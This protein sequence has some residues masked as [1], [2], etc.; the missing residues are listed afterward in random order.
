M[1]TRKRT[2]PSLNADDD[3][4]ELSPSKPTPA[5]LSAVKKRKLNTYGS[6]NKETSVLT[7]LTDLFGLGR[8]EKENISA[9]GEKDEL[10][11]DD[12]EGDSE[13]E[14]EEGD[15]WEVPDEEEPGMVKSGTRARGTLITPGKGT[16][17]SRGKG[18]VGE[19]KA[20]KKDIYEVDDSEEDMTGSTNVRAKYS[21]YRI[22]HA[23]NSAS[24]VRE[25]EN[26]TPQRPRGRPPKLTDTNMPSPKRP[27][28]KPR[29]ADILKKAKALS[30][31]AI[32]HQMVENGR[33]SAQNSEEAQTSARRRSRRSNAEVEEVD[34]G[35]VE[36]EAQATT[37]PRRRE[38]PKHDAVESVREAPKG[39][40]TP[41]K[42]R[43]V[44]SRKSVAFESR[45]DIDL[46]FKDLPD[47]VNKI[48]TLKKGRKPRVLLY[49]DTGEP[50]SKGGKGK[51]QVHSA[52]G[53]PQPEA[54]E[55]DSDD[56]PCA[57]CKGLDS[58][59]GNEII[60]CDNCDFAAHQKCY[61]VLKIPKGDWFCRDCQPDENED[62]LG[63]EGDNDVSVSKVFDDFPE[64]EGCEDHLRHMQRVLLDRLTG[65]KPV[66][67]R[68]H[69]EEMRKVHQVIEQT[70]LAGEGNSMLII[71]ARGCGKTTVSL[72]FGDL[73]Q[74]LSIVQ[75]VESV[76]SDLSIDHRGN[77]HVVRLNGFIHTDD[78]LALKEIWRQLGREIDAEDEMTGKVDSTGDFSPYLC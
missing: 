29:K 19:V 3:E 43:T 6:K 55:A 8:S 2:R 48:S 35:D 62:P 17:T 49:E 18:K 59:K 63:L 20:L 1:S 27:A 45:D 32:F 24:K 54:E 16:P 23:P 22:P 72:P 7:K 67:L 75:L 28:G 41:T 47:S 33:K 12:E 73:E 58:K 14:K 53:T 50:T 38:R 36:E 9:A 68:G 74:L 44:K 66:K 60:L 30:N 4:D 51:K 10:A 34:D 70:V 37:S 21:V 39:I 71:G 69:D 42:N 5:P 57:I 64:I 77:F 25:E 76:I 56:E 65:Q 31:E 52:E 40:L 46:G 15:I 11:D 61:D 78:K 26:T 13:G